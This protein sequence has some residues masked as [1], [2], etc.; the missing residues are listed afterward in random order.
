MKTLSKIEKNFFIR[1]KGVSGEPAAGV[2]IN[3]GG[4]STFPLKLGKRPRCLF[5]NLMF[6]IALGILASAI[7]QNLKAPRLERKK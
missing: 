5:P 1:R 2:R 4:L 6:N 3:G 7:R